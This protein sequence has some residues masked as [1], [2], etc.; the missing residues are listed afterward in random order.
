MELR[1]KL[2]SVESKAGLSVLVLWA[3]LSLLSV[4]WLHRYPMKRGDCSQKVL[5]Y[6]CFLLLCIRR[7]REHLKKKAAPKDL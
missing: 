7:D 1:F 4:L 2:E 5:P 3:G 6:V